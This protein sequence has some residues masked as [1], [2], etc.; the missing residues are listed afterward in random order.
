MKYLIDA[1]NL[2]GKLGLLNEENFDKIL[3]DKLNFFVSEKKCDVYLVFD[4]LDPL[5]DKLEKNNLKIIYTPRDSY[6][7]NADDKIMELLDNFLEDD[8]V[9]LI[10]GDFGLIDKAIKESIKKSKR[11]KLKIEDAND[12]IWRLD[13]KVILEREDD[14]SEDDKSDINKEMLNKFKNKKYGN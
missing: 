1:N 3:I 7:K 9:I 8:E 4:S 13:K 10:T 14:L 6:Y 11:N 12:F 2:A 5:G